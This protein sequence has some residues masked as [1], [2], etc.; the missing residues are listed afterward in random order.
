MKKNKLIFCFVICLLTSPLFCQRPNGYALVIGVSNNPKFEVSNRLL[1]SDQDAYAFK[2]FILSGKSAIPFS[3]PNIKLL[4]N[5]NATRTKINE[6]IVWLGNRV[7]PDDVVYI[8]YSGH[9]AEDNA[10]WVYLMPYDSDPQLPQDKG[11]RIDYFF[12]LLKNYLSSDN[13]VFFID[14]CYS[15]SMIT[16]GI[17]KGTTNTFSQ[18][19]NEALS[20]SFAESSAS[21]MSILSAGSNQRSWED[22]NLHS[23]VYTYFLLKG[24]N[25]DAEIEID[26]I[27]TAGEIMRYLVDNVD[28]Y[29][30][31]HFGN[32]QTPVRSAKFNST[33]PFS[34]I[35]D[36][37]KTEIAAD[38][39]YQKNKN[40]NILLNEANKYLTDQNFDE[41]IE[42]CNEI[43]RIDP[44]Y[45][46]AY[47]C[48]GISYW[49]KRNYESAILNYR[50]A[51][52]LDSLE[53]VSYNNL[54]Y[55]YLKFMNYS[56]AIKYLQK[57][58]S[59][60]VS[61]ATAYNLGDAYRDNGQ[62][63]EALE[64]HK[65]TCETVSNLKQG[66]EWFLW[67]GW[68]LNFS[69][70]SKNDLANMNQFIMAISKED[71]LALMHYSLSFDYALIGNYSNADIEFNKARQN[72]QKLQYNYYFSNEINHI[73]NFIELNNTQKAWFNNK[74]LILLKV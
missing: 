40:I 26:K 43:I 39:Q 62:L 54:G 46:T 57:S 17:A 52:A 53:I 4:V 20:K 45:A 67:D 15:G 1:F 49:G 22:K 65:Y 6:S 72:D 35:T 23:G 5:E 69:L 47:T 27:I 71:K 37:Q 31:S 66:Q 58:Y 14:A 19:I 30:K 33:F 61:A 56:S 55:L 50:K 74:R 11:I 59:I 18:D 13:I 12:E 3:E 60:S 29:V 38:E 63:Q 44:L 28:E 73:I 42:K 32:N 21:I 7:N 8:F 41:A 2:M 16:G 36:D 51:I 64:W 68:G 9:G 34:V 25:G 24:L 48:L 10:G 70:L